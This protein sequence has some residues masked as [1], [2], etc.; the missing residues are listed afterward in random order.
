[1][2][3]EGLLCRASLCFISYSGVSRNATIWSQ[4]KGVISFVWPL[5]EGV[6]GVP[7][8]THKM[9]S[10]KGEIRMS[11]AKQNVIRIIVDDN[12]DTDVDNWHKEH[13]LANMQEQLSKSKE[14]LAKL[15]IKELTKTPNKTD[16][17]K[18]I[19][20]LGRVAFSEL[21]SK[22]RL[23]AIEAYKPKDS[24]ESK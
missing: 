21:D 9:D 6:Y 13:I 16:L 1:M 19:F 5:L 7:T 20:E 4:S 11:D 24:T 2:V 14:E 12:T 18:T 23:A 10:D 15:S 22:G 8:K 17:T 3:I